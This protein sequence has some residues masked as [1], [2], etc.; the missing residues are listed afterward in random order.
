MK[1]LKRNLVKITVEPYLGVLA[2]PGTLDKQRVYGNPVD[3][4]VNVAPPNSGSTSFTSS[5]YVNT[6]AFGETVDYDNIILM[7]NKQAD[8][9]GI[10]EWSKIT[11]ENPH[12]DFEIKRVARDQTLTSI[13]AKRIIVEPVYT[14]PT[15][16]DGDSE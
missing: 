15:T 9:A 2:I 7:T 1:L 16:G 4:M 3:L 8:M 10:N 14:P 12:R 6:R 5:G 11:M 13:A